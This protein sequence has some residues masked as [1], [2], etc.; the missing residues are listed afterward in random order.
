MNKVIV[1]D[2]RKKEIAIKD[3]K[4]IVFIVSWLS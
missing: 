4:R 2:L 1:I 3:K